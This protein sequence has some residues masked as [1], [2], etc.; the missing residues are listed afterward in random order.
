ME[1]IILASVVI[2]AACATCVLRKTYD[3][4]DE[5]LGMDETEDGNYGNNDIGKI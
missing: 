2:I 4:S 1:Y 3:V 5:E